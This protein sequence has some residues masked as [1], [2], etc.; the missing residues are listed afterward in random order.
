MDAL[1]ISGSATRRD[2]SVEV[3]SNG[4]LSVIQDEVDHVEFV[5]VADFFES[6]AV[7]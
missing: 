7:G 6:M 3:G 4:V 1:Q 2:E 5:N